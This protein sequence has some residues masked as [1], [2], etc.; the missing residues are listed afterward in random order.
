ML[1]VII[2]IIGVLLSVVA[3]TTYAAAY[4]GLALIVL[5]EVLRVGQHSLQELQGH[6]LHLGGAG[7]VG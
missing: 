2:Y 6:N 5:A 7:S 3:D 4:A 1:A